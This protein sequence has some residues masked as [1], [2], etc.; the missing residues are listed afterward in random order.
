MTEPRKFRDL[1]A[2]TMSGVSLA[3]AK[4]RAAKMIAE[5]PLQELRRARSLSQTQLA[6]LLG[7]TQPEV[8]KIEQR[9][10]MY[11]STLRSYIEAMGGALQIVAH[12]PD[13]DVVIN[14]FHEI[15]PIA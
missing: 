13:G 8:S 5:M 12:F 2:R 14:Q 3:R 15:E 1:T 7:T 6:S 11:V 4:S 10:D 9:A